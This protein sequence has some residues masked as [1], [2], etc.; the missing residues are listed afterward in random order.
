MDDQ[1]EI[2]N[3]APVISS[4]L[5]NTKTALPTLFNS[6]KIWKNCGRKLDR[7]Y[8]LFFIFQFEFTKIKLLQQQIQ[9]KLLTFS[10]RFRYRNGH[11]SSPT[12]QTQVLRTADLPVNPL[13]A[14]QCPAHFPAQARHPGYLVTQDNNK[15][16]S[17]FS[18]SFQKLNFL[19]IPLLCLHELHP[20]VAWNKR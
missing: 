4:V 17:E 18:A 7:N 3:L 12:D 6:E 1:T 13:S 15:S 14:A 5:L 10:F 16:L 11:A 19:Q 20:T 2:G 8:F 9:T